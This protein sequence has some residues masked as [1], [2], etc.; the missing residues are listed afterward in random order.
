MNKKGYSISGWIEGVSLVILFIGIFGYVISD[1]NV[2]YGRDFQIGLGSQIN[3]S[4][5]ALIDTAESTTGEIQG[6]EA[7]FSTSQGLTLKSSWAILKSIGTVLWDI[8]TG[9]FIETIVGW[10][11]LNMEVAIILR[12]LYIFS[13]VFAIITVLFRRSL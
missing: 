2:H 4:R 9:G 3:A 5:Q 6:G 11:H 1:M 12:V 10:M 13:I 7:E 8:I